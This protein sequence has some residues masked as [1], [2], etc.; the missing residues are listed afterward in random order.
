MDVYLQWI[1]IKVSEMCKLQT[2]HLQICVC[3]L[4]LVQFNDS[5]VTFKLIRSSVFKQSVT[6]VNNGML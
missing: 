2:T 6:S 5:K 1:N 4:T 3:L